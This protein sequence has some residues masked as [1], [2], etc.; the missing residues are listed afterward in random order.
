MHLFARGGRHSRVT[1]RAGIVRSLASFILS[2]WSLKQGVPDA[3][4][5]LEAMSIEGEFGG[6]IFVRL[7]CE[8]ICVAVSIVGRKK[9][10]ISFARFLGGV[11]PSD[12]GGGRKNNMLEATLLSFR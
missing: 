7:N 9:S 4:L 2:G 3:Y 12:S 8:T 5:M 1:G 6:M 11:A 10:C